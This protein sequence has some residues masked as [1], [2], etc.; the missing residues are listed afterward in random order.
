MTNGPTTIDPSRLAAARQAYQADLRANHPDLMGTDRRSNAGDPFITDS[1]GNTTFNRWIDASN[2]REAQDETQT[3]IRI[4][5]DGKEQ[6]ER[7]AAW[8]TVPSFYSREAN[9]QGSSILDRLADLQGDG[10]QKMQDIYNKALG[11][12]G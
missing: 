9:S 2:K 6:E 11:R 4:D 3:A 7:M 12:I 8:K 10:Y 5:K 1:E